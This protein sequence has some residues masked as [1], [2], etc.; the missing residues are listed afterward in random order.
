M[1]DMVAA[2]EV[3]DAKVARWLCTKSG[4][5]VSNHSL[6]KKAQNFTKTVTENS[7]GKQVRQID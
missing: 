7:K 1:D 6:E 2:R 3:L 5:S 4:K